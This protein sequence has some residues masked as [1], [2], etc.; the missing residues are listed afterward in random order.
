MGGKIICNAG[1][2]ALMPATCVIPPYLLLELR[3]PCCCCL[4]RFLR[5]PLRAG[6]GRG[7]VDLRLGFGVLLD[8]GTQQLQLG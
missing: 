3:I 2:P 6:G 7:D 1:P 4:L 5:Q 8:G